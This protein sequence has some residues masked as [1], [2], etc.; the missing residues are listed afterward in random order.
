MIP[1]VVHFIFGL[2]PD[3]G[4]KPF[5][6]IHW[7]AVES[8]ARHLKPNK[9]RL[10]CAN[11]PFGAWWERCRQLVEVIDIVAP[12]RIFGN[13]LKYAAHK[14][15]LLRL[16]VLNEQGG[17][18]LDLDVLVVAPFPDCLFEHKFVMGTETGIGL[19][20]AVIMAQPNSAFGRRWLETFVKFDGA[21]W[22]QHAVRIPGKLAESAKPG[23]IEI[24]PSH[25]FFEPMYDAA[26]LDQLFLKSTIQHRGALAHHLWE[27]FSWPKFNL[28]EMTEQDIL[29]GS[30][31]FHLEA[32]KYLKP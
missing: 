30:G 23:E 11:R 2:R 16:A 27:S 26:G 4:G 13:E 28:G 9:I 31:L 32:R 17:I 12:D 21:D 25:T 7:A 19:C 24:L 6:A 18:Y 20:N 10:Y 8:A 15:D 14:T 5:S 3:F 29:T 22:N 1:R